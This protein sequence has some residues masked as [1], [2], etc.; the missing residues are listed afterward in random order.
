MLLEKIFCVIMNLLNSQII[1]Q[2]FLEFLKNED[3][4]AILSNIILTDHKLNY[5]ALRILVVI[6]RNAKKM[7][8]ISSL[9]FKMIEVFTYTIQENQEVK[10][11]KLALEGLYSLFSME[12]EQAENMK[13][14]SL[15]LKFQSLNGENILIALQHHD[16]MDVY[17]LVFIIFDEFFQDNSENY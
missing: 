7:G 4:F 9:A 12:K 16:D 11:L 10:I 5:E 15:V 3:R 14:K 6:T 8:D 1:F 2:I 13:N 17:N